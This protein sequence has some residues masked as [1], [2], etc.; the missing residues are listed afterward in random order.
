MVWPIHSFAICGVAWYQGESN[1]YVGMADTYA[2]LLPAMIGAWRG[3]WQQPQLPVIIFQIA[4][5]RKP[6]V[7][8]NEPS[9]IAVLQEAQWKTTL[10][11]PL[12]ALVVTMDLGEPDVH[13][14]RKELAA[15]RAK[16]AA[17]AYGRDL[18]YRSPVFD[19]V[20]IDEATAVIRFARCGGGLVSRDA[21]LS[22]F[23]IAGED[24][25]F[26][27]ADARIEVDT[28]LVSSPSVPHPVAVRYGW[29]DLPKTNL[30][31]KEGLPAAPFRTDTWP[32]LAK[33]K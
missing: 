18:E 31:S 33:G 14:H 27:F 9:G 7:D 17:L 4:P 23:A 24:R 3:A 6:Q 10:K 20:K 22:G 26:V 16:S 12:T 2:D 21:T 11:T 15:D 32:V 13:Y 1:A 29:V 25:R 5:N 19:T 30:F 8:A 28:V